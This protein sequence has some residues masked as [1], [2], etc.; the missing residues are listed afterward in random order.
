[1]S[2]N[3]KSLQSEKFLSRR[4]I[5]TQWQ[6]DYLNDDMDRFYDVAF[7][8]I[9]SSLNAQPND[10]ILDAGCGYCYHTVRL[11]RSGA[12]I[13]AVDFSEAALAIGKQT[14]A[15]AGIL[16]QVDLKQED[17]TKLSFADDTF[18]FV[19]SW[20]VLMHVPE[21]EK[22]LAELARVLKSGGVLVLCENNLD[23]LDVVI[24]ERLVNAVKKLLGRPVPE[25]RTTLSGSEAWMQ[26]Q[27]GG[28]MVRKTDMQ[29]LS[30]FLA[31]QRLIEFKRTAGQFTEAYTNLP[32]KVLKRCVYALNMFYYKHV[33]LPSFAIGNVSYYRKL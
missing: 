11:A 16:N 2:T 9:V 29:Y 27:T 20:G 24:R 15:S 25:I 13:T 26:E 17:L 33:G 1:M 28:L 10:R 22:A 12:S 6:S 3:D 19:V 23:S 32:W 30:R 7:S 4:D 31:T 18:D 8:D 14:I 21:L 5:H